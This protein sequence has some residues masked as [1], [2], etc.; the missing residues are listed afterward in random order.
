MS[1]STRVRRTLAP[2]REDQQLQSSTRT[3]LAPQSPSV[4]AQCA[5]SPAKMH[6]VTSATETSL[7]GRPT[8]CAAISELISKTRSENRF[9][10]LQR[11]SARRSQAYSHRE[12]LSLKSRRPC[13]LSRSSRPKRRDRSRSRG[14]RIRFRTLL[15]QPINLV[16]IRQQIQNQTLLA[17]LARTVTARIVNHRG[18]QKEA[19]LPMPHVL[20]QSPK[21]ARMVIFLKVPIL[22]TWMGA[23]IR[24]RQCQPTS[25]SRS[26]MSGVQAH[27]LE[28]VTEEAQMI[29]AQMA[30]EIPIQMVVRAMHHLDL[31]KIQMT[32]ITGEVLS[33]AEVDLEGIEMLLTVAHL[34]TA[35]ACPA[36]RGPCIM[37]S[38]HRRSRLVLIRESIGPIYLCPGQVRPSQRPEESQHQRRASIL[39]RIRMPVGCPETTVHSGSTQVSRRRLASARKEIRKHLPSMQGQLSLG[40]QRVMEPIHHQTWS[41][42]RMRDRRGSRDWIRIPSQR[43]RD[44]QSPATSYRRP[45]HLRVVTKSSLQSRDRT[46]LTRL[47]LMQKMTLTAPHQTWT[48]LD[49]STM[50][51]TRKGSSRYPRMTSSETELTKT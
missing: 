49:P 12:S 36:S 14:Q 2:R 43:L 48:S 39:G 6:L 18:L 9:K 33:L 20:V 16:E 19:S 8:S 46:R 7:S 24:R 13:R 42:S 31:V 40:L 44:Q 4:A 35:R 28:A 25:P 32:Q 38:K 17:T 45:Q 50:N 23:S 15:R 26:V 30:T 3:S 11:P 5:T 21:I 47:Q 29:A 51:L 37:T 41:P 22:H 1:I 10:F 34:T 27:S